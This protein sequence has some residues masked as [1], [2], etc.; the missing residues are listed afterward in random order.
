MSTLVIFIVAGAALATGALL[1]VLL[2]QLRAVRRIE[3]LRI[4]LAA[5]QVRLESS[6]LQ[7]ADRL[8]LLEQSETRLRA[9]FD[10]LAGET[11][12]TNSE[13]FLRLAR[14]AL[15]RDQVLAQGALKEREQA[16]AQ[17]VEPLRAALERTEGQVQA[18]ERERR[19]AFAT[20]RT[21]I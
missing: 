1:G 3:T 18:L 6:V 16:I 12:R 15:G 11:L 19:D 14:E 17:L 9:A 7:D 21:Q 2:T 13:L 8:K 4:E 10:S 5:A 20:R